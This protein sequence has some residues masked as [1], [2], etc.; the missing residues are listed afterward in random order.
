MEQTATQIINHT[1][2]PWTT[3][4]GI[5][6]QT[7]YTPTDGGKPFYHTIARTD[8][9]LVPP[10]QQGANAHLIAA[11]PDLLAACEGILA[12]FHESVITTESLAEFPALKAVADAIAKATGQHLRPAA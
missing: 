12:N 8:Q 9:P 7:I 4:G 2:G 6:V 3:D 5:Y 10:G 11:A 1:P